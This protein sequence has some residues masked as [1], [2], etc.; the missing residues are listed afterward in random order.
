MPEC[1]CLQVTKAP[2]RNHC[3]DV[4]TFFFLGI[5][6]VLTYIMQLK[7]IAQH[8]CTFAPHAIWRTPSFSF[9][10]PYLA[11]LRTFSLRLSRSLKGTS[12]P[13]WKKTNIAGFK[14]SLTVQTVGRINTDRMANPTI[15]K[16]NPARDER[17]RRFLQRFKSSPLYFLG[18]VVV[19]FPLACRLSETGA[20]G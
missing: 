3:D 17:A 11:G 16:H 7:E 10:L 4:M 19:F 1:C 15:D 8:F 20:A 18:G 9:L 6:H 5:G 14:V 2:L 12:V 13:C